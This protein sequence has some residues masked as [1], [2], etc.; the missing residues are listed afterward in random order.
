MVL[1]N[2]VAEIE[3]TGTR[4]ALRLVDAEL[5]K[6][7]FVVLPEDTPRT[8]PASRFAAARMAWRRPFTAF[9]SC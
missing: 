2:A 7:P 3:R 1:A 8:A 4:H 5:S 6:D 9:A